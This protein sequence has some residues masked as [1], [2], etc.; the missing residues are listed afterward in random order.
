MADYKGYMIERS[1]RR[2]DF[3]VVSPY[4]ETIAILI[5][6][7]DGE[8]V[9]ANV[10]GIKPRNSYKHRGE[11]LEDIAEQHRALIGVT[12]KN[13]IVIT[14]IESRTIVIETVQNLHLHSNSLEIQISAAQ[15]EEIKVAVEKADAGTLKR[16]LKEWIPKALVG[17]GIEELLAMLGIG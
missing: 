10:K 13:P 6:T 15:V 9:H 12:D 7:L 2:G 5:G 17:T 16:I 14:P 3:A 11:L 1:E 8:S 4:K